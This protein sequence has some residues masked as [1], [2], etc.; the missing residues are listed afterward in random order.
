MTG[1][2]AAAC[3]GGDDS[4][5]VCSMPGHMRD[6]DLIRLSRMWTRMSALSSSGRGRWADPGQWIGGG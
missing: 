5:H 1:W 2:Q 4:K 3:Q 6:T